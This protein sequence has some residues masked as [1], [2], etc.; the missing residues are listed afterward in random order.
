MGHL[1]LFVLLGG[2]VGLTL[3]ASGGR[4]A[5]RVTAAILFATTFGPLTEVIQAYT[6]RDPQFSDA[7]LDIVGALI[8]LAIGHVSWRR[9]NKHWRYPS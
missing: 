7:L 8:G 5:T 3:S 6:A 2:W 4:R 1:G 9:L